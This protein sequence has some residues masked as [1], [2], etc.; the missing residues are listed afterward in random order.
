MAHPHGLFGRRVA[1]DARRPLT[2]QPRRTVL[3][4]LGVSHPP[5]E[6]DGH[7]LLAIAEAKHR[8]AKLEH[9][10]VDLWRTLCV[11]ARRT[12][13]EDN[14][15]R[16]HGGKLRRR[17]ATGHDLRIHVEVTHAAGYELPVLGT[18]IEHGYKLPRSGTLH[19]TSLST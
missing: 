18:K 16:P 9:S 2:A 5:T 19:V 3:A 12:T 6:R 13:G 8:N 1:Q 7:D 17:D 15:G 11:H 10:S 14:R 4:P